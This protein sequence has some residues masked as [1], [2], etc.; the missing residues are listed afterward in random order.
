M[1]II[2]HIAIQSYCHKLAVTKTLPNKT[3][4]AVDLLLKGF[5]ASQQMEC[6]LSTRVSV[7]FWGF[8]GK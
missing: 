1:L 5:A 8:L 3:L 2:N 6:G 7:I 4:P